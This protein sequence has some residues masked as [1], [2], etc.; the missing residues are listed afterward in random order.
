MFA[1]PPFPPFPPFPPVS[2]VAPKS[3]TRNRLLLLGIPA[4][5]VAVAVVGAFVLLGHSSSDAPSSGPITVEGV[6]IQYDSARTTDSYEVSVGDT[7]RPSSASNT[8]L[9][10][11]YKVLSDVP[12]QPGL[13]WSVTVTD[14]SGASHSPSVSSQSY[15]NGLVSQ[16]EWVTVVPKDSSSYVLRFPDGQTVDLTG[17]I[18]H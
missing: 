9:I 11:K 6:Q 18:S 7:I 10:V 15:K 8:L 3:G 2:P 4:L 17:A 5:V 1:P 12:S 16:L 13:D 14:S